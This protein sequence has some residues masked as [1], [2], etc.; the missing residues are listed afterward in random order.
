MGIKMRTFKTIS[1]VIGIYI[2]ALVMEVIM[3]LGSPE[4]QGGVSVLV[5]LGILGSL[6][7]IGNA[8]RPI[9]G[10]PEPGLVGCTYLGL[11]CRCVG[12]AA[13]NSHFIHLAC[14][15]ISWAKPSSECCNP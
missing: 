3:A 14:L 2:A 4:Y 10:T 8:W 13:I 1:I 5:I 11:I 7:P 15:Y 6:A 9:S 12:N